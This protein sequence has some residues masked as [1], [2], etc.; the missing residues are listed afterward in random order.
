MSP[1]SWDTQT[2]A[3]VT[4]MWKCWTCGSLKLVSMVGDLKPQWKMTATTTTTTNQK[5]K[6]D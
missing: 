5:P 6:S 3:Q 1:F 2:E 4:E